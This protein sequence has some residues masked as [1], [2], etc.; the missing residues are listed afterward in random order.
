MGYVL[1]RT[2]ELNLP[3]VYGVGTDDAR[4]SSDIEQEVIPDADG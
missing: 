1:R 2:G 4:V 3:V